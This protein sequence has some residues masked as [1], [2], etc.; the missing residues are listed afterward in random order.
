[1]PS[2]YLTAIKGSI[3]TF[4]VSA[5]TIYNIITKPP[6]S[7]DSGYY[8]SSDYSSSSFKNISRFGS[9]QNNPFDKIFFKDPQY[10]LIQAFKDFICKNPEAQSLINNYTRSSRITETRGPTNVNEL[11]RKIEEGA[12]RVSGIPG[13]S[14]LQYGTII[15]TLKQFYHDVF[16]LFADQYGNISTESMNNLVNSIPKI[17]CGNKG[18]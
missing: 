6:S 4:P 18:S 13:L 3:N 14:P 2:E 12:S 5:I 9:V 17:I 15:R 10:K 16:V 1:M 7:S 11:D 8:S